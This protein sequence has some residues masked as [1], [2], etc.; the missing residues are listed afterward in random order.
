MTNVGG[1]DVD[2]VVIGAGVV[3]LAVA[4]EL[5]DGRAVAVLERH[6]APARENSSHNSGVIHAGLYYPAGWLKTTL[7]VEGNRLLYRWAREHGVRAERIGKLIVAIDEA[8]LPGL[9]ELE[10]AARANGVPDVHRVSA[11]EARD[12]EPHVRCAGALFSGSSGVVDQMG[13]V[14]SFHRAA[15]ARGAVFAFRHAV[16]RIERRAPAGFIIAGT[17]PDGRPFTVTAGVVVNSAGMAAD[18]LVAT[19]G[20][21]IDGSGTTPRMRQRL[22]KGRYYDIVDS[23]KARLVSRLVY[24]LPHGDRAGLGVHLTLDV[25]GNAR[26]GPDTEWLPADATPDFR[27]ADDRRDEFL[28][29]ARR[30]LPWLERDDLAP[31]QVGYRPKLSGPGEPPSDFLIWHD[32]GYVH[33]GGI[34]SPGLTASLAIAHYVHALLK[35]SRPS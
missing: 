24:P 17:G 32:R 35:R 8:D 23:T 29:S 28:A 2:V 7:C 9:D 14:A 12:L 21:D 31:G 16:E 10:R 26:L 13:L 19:L 15:A 34:E 22:N 6:D 30:Y 5:S 1:S 18:R 25:D 11:S 33:L 20:Y 27:S 3:G 4:L